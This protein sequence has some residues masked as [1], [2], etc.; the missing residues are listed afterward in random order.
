MMFGLHNCTVGAAERW[1]FKRNGERV[2]KCDG[3]KT[4]SRVCP[5]TCTIESA[6]L[7]RFPISDQSDWHSCA[8]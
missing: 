7:V 5:F 2:K 3:K 4:Q 6:N 1:V 8:Y